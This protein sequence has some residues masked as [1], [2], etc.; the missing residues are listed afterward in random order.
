MSALPERILAA[1]ADLTSRPGGTIYLCDLRVRLGDV[2]R[3]ELDRAL[4]DMDDRRDI[5]LEPDP[6]RAGL[7]AE[8][9]AAAT[10][11]AGRD[12]HLMRAVQHDV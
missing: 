1:Y 2:D 6:D 12:M 8:M 4:L 5:Q 7:T 3:D 11:L 9:R 10:W